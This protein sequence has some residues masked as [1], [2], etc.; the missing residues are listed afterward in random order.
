VSIAVGLKSRDGV[1]IGADSE[2]VD[3]TAKFK[4]S[5]VFTIV[6]KGARLV[7]A[8]AGHP[9]HIHKVAGI[10]KAEL[11]KLPGGKHT[12]RWEDPVRQC[13]DY[14]VS[15]VYQRFIFGHPGSDTGQGPAAQFVIGFWSQSLGTASL[16]SN[17]DDVVDELN[18][19]AVAG[20]GSS[21][22]RCIGGNLFR[23]DMSPAEA[24]RLA[25][26]MLHLT[27][28]NVIH[29]GM[30]SQ[31]WVLTN[32]GKL[33]AVSVSEL[34]RCEGYSDRFVRASNSLF[35]DLARRRGKA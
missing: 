1:I 7:C 26:H 35:F 15:E 20:M 2:A 5:K 27:K 3:G 10:I 24:I 29:C 34:S 28:N 12:D 14:A 4:T 32:H 8:T 22:A 21:F 16:L 33:T 13:I 25:V 6:T 30:Q 23:P 19:F 11:K 17:E 9:A 31:L 18:D